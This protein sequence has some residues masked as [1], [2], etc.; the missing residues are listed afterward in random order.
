MDGICGNTN[1]VYGQ[2]FILFPNGKLIL[3]NSFFPPEQAILCPPPSIE[4]PNYCQTPEIPPS[5][6]EGIANETMAMVTAQTGQQQPNLTAC[7][8]REG[9]GDVVV[10]I[11]ANSENGIGTA[12]GEEEENSNRGNNH[13]QRPPPTVD[14]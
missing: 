9:I 12:T 1:L 10:P 2:K 7:G 4:P 6:R 13:Q 8:Q 14:R 11:V 3:I 5:T